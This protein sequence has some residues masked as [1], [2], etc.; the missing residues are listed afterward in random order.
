MTTPSK[1][2]LSAPPPS[3]PVLISIDNTN[4]EPI[5]DLKVEGPGVTLSQLLVDIESRGIT[6]CRRPLDDVDDGAINQQE[7]DVNDDCGEEAT[8]VQGHVQGYLLK[9]QS[10]WLMM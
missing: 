5:R 7:S 2:V 10:K 8:Q 6:T 1:S 4:D 9:V 3:T